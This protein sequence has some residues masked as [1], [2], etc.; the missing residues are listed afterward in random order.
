MEDDY[1]VGRI[2][3][4]G[5]IA[6]IDAGKTTVSERF[7]YYSGKIR[8]IGE[9]HDGQAEM[10]W[11]ELEKERG[12][13]I[14][15]ASTVFSWRDSRI[16]L[17]DT[18]GHVDFTGE[19]ERSLRI[20]DG[21]IGVFCAVAGVQSQ[22]EAVWHRADRFQV[23]R[24]VFVNKMDR[25]GASFARTIEEVRTR[26]HPGTVPVQMPIGEGKDFCGVVDLIRQCA[27]YWEGDFG[28]HVVRREIPPSMKERAREGR[29]NIIEAVS[30]GDAA[31]L[32]QF[33][34]EMHIDEDVLSHA[35]RCE[36]LAGRIVPALCGSALRN[37]GIQTLLDAVVAY[38]PSPLDRK[39]VEYIDLRTG[40]MET[41]QLSEQEIKERKGPLR[42]QVFKISGDSYTGKLAYVR[43]YSGH[44]KTG[45]Q[46]VC[47][48]TGKTERV[49]KIVRMHANIKEEIEEAGPGDIAAL[50]GLKYALTG[51][52]LHEK[53]YPVLFESMD[54]PTPVVSVALEAYM[55]S[56]EKRLQEAALRLSEEDP[57]F[58][59]SRNPETGQLVLSGMGE[60][61]LEIITQ[62]ML[63]EY[64]VRVR[65]GKPEV[66]FKETIQSVA[67]ASE[68][69][70]REYNGKRQ[71]AA[72]HVSLSPLER[73]SGF[74]YRNEVSEKILPPEFARAAEKGIRE[75]L[76]SGVL[77]GYP[78]VDILAVVKHAECF[79]QESSEF[80]FTIAASLATRKGL[81]A[82]KPIILEPVMRMEVF[83]P[84]EYLGE[85]ISSIITKAGR[86]ESVEDRQGGKVVQA[87]VSLRNLFGY[88]TLL[89]SLTKGRATSSMHF[90]HYEKLPKNSQD[91]LIMHS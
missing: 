71:R 52:T 18:P 76:E 9:V 58:R 5:I 51:E 15:A 24:L 8:K 61:H 36:V 53:G 44:V 86:I 56:D 2:R 46:V 74:A 68:E 30:E 63:R 43:I 65:I 21:A 91:E 88:T 19:V 6:H 3:N 75:T 67:F 34:N 47:G 64:G 70:D 25:N 35:L 83:V 20:L 23:P 31:I 11:M 80:A 17:I 90:S 12:I 59:L 4:I 82:A 79:E 29:E 50:A 40:R 27:W 39:P 54:F 16:N 41:L 87:F 33:V 45:D 55:R 10:D 77:N 48:S 28:E 49:M 37:K 66:A 32:E 14:T 26:L 42:A 84:E 57:S 38:L 22:S 85:V 81:I 7:L 73:G 13:T 1:P 62:R 69:F 72:I 78:V 89:R 60:L